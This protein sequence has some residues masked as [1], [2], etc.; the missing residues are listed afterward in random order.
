MRVISGGAIIPALSALKNVRIPDV[1]GTIARDARGQIAVPDPVLAIEILS[2]SNASDTRLNVA[3][4]RS[5]P[6][7]REIVVV[8]SMRIKAEVHRRLASGEWPAAPKLVEAGGRLRI[9]VADLDCAIELVY[10]DTWLTDA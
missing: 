10:R 6:S 4:Y 2:P 9:G 7:M 5:I 3:A 1:V 8:N